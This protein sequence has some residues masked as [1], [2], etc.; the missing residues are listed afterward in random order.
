MSKAQ[1]KK[2]A[3]SK[4]HPINQTA[5]SFSMVNH[6]DLTH[7]E[8]GQ[9]DNS[10]NRQDS[11]NNLLDQSAVSNL[12]NQMMHDPAAGLNGTS[13]VQQEDPY[14]LNINND[15]TFLDGN[16]EQVVPH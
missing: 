8:G 6:S 2:E 7:E 15:N 13:K 14:V 11:G 4:Q 3:A 1:R 9:L 5:S 16:K 12:E 10:F